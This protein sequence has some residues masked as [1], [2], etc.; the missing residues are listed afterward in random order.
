MQSTG[1]TS[2]QLASFVSMQG[3]VMMYVMSPARRMEL[4]SAKKLYTQTDRG[5]RFHVS[6]KGCTNRRSET[7]DLMRD[8]WRRSPVSRVRMATGHINTRL[9]LAFVLSVPGVGAASAQAGSVVGSVYDSVAGGPLVDATVFLWDTPHRGVT[10]PEGH[11]RIDDVPAGRYSILFSHDRLDELGVSSGQTSVDVQVGREAKVVLASPSIATLVTSLC[12]V[13][14]RPPQSGAIA[15]RVVDAESKMS[16]GGASVTLS[17]NV[18]DRPAPTTLELASGADG[19]YHTCAIPADEPV[20]LSV[21]FIGREGP[22]RE[23]TVSGG[24]FAEGSVEVVEVGPTRVSGLLLDA[25]TDRPVE[26][27]EA[28]LR[29]TSHRTLS[30]HQG[31]FRFS[32]IAHGTYML[33]TDHV[34]YGIKM[35]TLVVPPTTAISVEMRLDTRPIEI[36]PLTVSTETA[37]VAIARRRGG[38]VITREEIDRLRQSSRDASDVIRSLHVPG[39]LVR[40]NSDGSICVGYTSGQVRMFRSNCVEMVI[41]INDAR[42]TDPDTALRMSPESIERMEVYKPLEAGTLFGLGGGN[43]VWVIYTRGN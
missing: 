14:Q 22:R 18:P 1:Q 38:I 34:A 36:A 6:V 2:T 29:G 30:D 31:G 26:G 13:E 15:G 23:I 39:V 24:G 7:Y 42:A 4:S 35:D 9:W 3:W 28:W 20:L 33:M 40:H 43:G 32:S 27:A 10:D 11:F 19:W 17:W 41:F 12:L 16:L 37:P 8:P 21:G 5:K 25:E